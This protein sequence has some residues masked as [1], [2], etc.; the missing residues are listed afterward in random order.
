VAY[1]TSTF[2]HFDYPKFRVAGMK[3]PSLC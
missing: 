1:T 3:S 2:M